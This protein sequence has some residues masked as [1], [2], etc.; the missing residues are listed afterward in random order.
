[1]RPARRI[2]R[3]RRA[4][5]RLLLLTPSR[6]A[7]GQAHG[8]SQR[9]PRVSVIRQRGKDDCGLACLAMLLGARGRPT[10]LGEL[11]SEHP[12][13]PG[14]V[15]AADLATLAARRGYRMAAFALAQPQALPSLPL[16]VIIHWAGTHFLIVERWAPWGAVVVDPAQGRRALPP[17]AFDTYF[18]GIVL[19]LEPVRA[20]A[21]C[22]Q[23]YGA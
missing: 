7:R 5:P 20:Q 2:T 11:L 18:S 16:P 1:M 12:P 23:H 19:T 22:L 17:A 3:T 6:R 14:G 9:R 21:A 10:E 8:A 15:S 4:V 13:K